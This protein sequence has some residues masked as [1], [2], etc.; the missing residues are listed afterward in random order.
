MNLRKF[1]NPLGI[2]FKEKGHKYY[3]SV[4]K[5]HVSVTTLLKKYA[6][7]FPKDAVIKYAK[8]HNRT[9]EDVQKEWDEKRDLGTEIGSWL[10]MQIENQLLN[11]VP[12]LSYMITNNGIPEDYNTK[13]EYLENYKIQIANYLE[14][15]SK[16]THV[17]NEIIVG[18]DI[19]AGQID[20]LNIEC[21]HDYKGFPLDTLV[22]TPNSFVKIKDLKIGDIV[23]DGNGKQTKVRHVSKIHNNPCYEIEFHTNQKIVSDHEHKWNVRKRKN[24]QTTIDKTL[25]TEQI[26]NYENNVNKTQRLKVMNSPAIEIKEKELLIDPYVV[27]LWLGDGNSHAST[28]I[29]KNPKVWDEIH[30]RGYKTSNN[31]EKN[32]DLIEYRTVYNIRHHLKA[33]NLIKNKHL[34]ECYLLGSYQQR[35]DL[36]RGFMDADGHYHRKR[37]RCVMVTTSEWQANAISNLAASLGCSSTV[38]TAK[39]TGF[40]KIDIPVWHICF[41]PKFN[42]FLCRNEDYVQPKR[43]QSNH[44]IIKNITKVD[45]VP[46]ICISVESDDSTYLV[47]KN[48]IKTHNTDKEIKFENSYSNWKGEKVHKKMLGPLSDLDDCNWNKYCLQINIYQ[49]LLPDHIKNNFTEPNKVIKFDR[50]SQDY[51]TLIIPDMQDRIKEIL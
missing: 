6:V 17:G 15:Q 12:D 44:K 43:S 30:L 21:I 26:F 3:S 22:P 48:F 50:F 27:G 19:H 40:N 16:Y 7:P 35:L 10:H 47:T 23:F 5:N 13:L 25:T 20:E 8:K 1:C 51:E 11:K 49:Y 41:T 38:F 29:S 37:K 34:P 2:V 33:L 32:P 4:N 36:L 18:N 31:L 14:W 46:T 9:V 42:P 39:T 24:S 45:T 28:I